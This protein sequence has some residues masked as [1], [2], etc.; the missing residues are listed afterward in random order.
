[1]SLLM[2]A[3]AVY[4]IL[5]AQGGLVSSPA[6]MHPD[7]CLF[8]RL[9]VSSLFPQARTSAHCRRAAG[10]HGPRVA[11]HRCSAHGLRCGSPGLIFLQI[12]CLGPDFSP[13]NSYT[14]L[15]PRCPA[16]S[17]SWGPGDGLGTK[18]PMAG[19]GSLPQGFTEMLVQLSH[20]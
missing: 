14:N 16:I 15:S 4:W 17:S 11:L 3:D 13:G 9:S 18:I 10:L 7:Y 20:C 6:K 19:A 5:G 2:V 1:M 8:P 12:H